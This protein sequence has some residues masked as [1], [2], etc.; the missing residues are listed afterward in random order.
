MRIHVLTVAEEAAY[1]AA[2]EALRAEAVAR[3]VPPLVLTT[4][5]TSPF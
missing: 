5:E 2:I 3:S 4:S 1:F